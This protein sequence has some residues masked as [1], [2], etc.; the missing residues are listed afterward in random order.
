MGS[1]SLGHPNLGDHDIK[2]SHV[3]SRF[4]HSTAKSEIT[5]V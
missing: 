5:E 4:G 1:S 3:V 2:G